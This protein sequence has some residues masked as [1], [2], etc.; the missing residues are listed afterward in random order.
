MDSFL[1]YLTTVFVASIIPGPSMILALTHGIKYGA[2]KTMATALGNTCA[3]LI[4][5]SISIAGLGAVLTASQ[6]LFLTLKYAG[7]AYLI[8]LGLKLMFSKPMT[9]DSSSPG[10]L[11]DDSSFGKRFSQGFYVATANP[12]AIV[13]FSAL[14]PQFIDTAA[15]PLSQY[16]GLV[17]PLS[18]IAFL[19]MMIYALGGAKITR[20]FIR[21][22]LGNY[23][24]RI[25][26]GSFITLGIGIVISEQ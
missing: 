10:N 2:K 3:S 7:A 17:I 12:K 21:G 5:A 23:F 14:F 9:I 22:N 1:I 24:N 8:Y 15:S 6:P 25:M 4:Q 13:F 20:F 16:L 11:A 18:I 19:C 26:G